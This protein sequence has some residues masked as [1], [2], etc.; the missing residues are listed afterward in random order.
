[1]LDM[2]VRLLN[3]PCVE[4]TVCGIN[5]V[6]RE[7]GTAKELSP[8]DHHHFQHQSLVKRLYLPQKLPQII[9]ISQRFLLRPLRTSLGSREIHCEQM[10]AIAE[11]GHR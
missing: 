8:S 1:M 3:P 11:T 10:P 9:L 7:S 5:C 6:A 4:S 2:V